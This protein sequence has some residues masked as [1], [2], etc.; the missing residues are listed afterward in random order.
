[1]QDRITSRICRLQ[2][3]LAR[4]L[5][6]PIIRFGDGCRSA[7]PEEQGIYRIFNPNTP[8]VTI[9]AGRTKTAAIG[10]RQRIYQNHLMGDQHGNLRSQLVN[11][12]MCSD[13]D[14]A[15]LYIRRS[16]AVQFLIVEDPDERAWL[17][18]FMLGVLAPQYCD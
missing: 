5:N 3:E 16:L 7:L 6:A 17:E 14:A 18:H 8:E 9:R 1:M 13:L 4:L 11:G 10:L 15:K 2:D 12:G